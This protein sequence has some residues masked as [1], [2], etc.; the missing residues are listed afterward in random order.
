PTTVKSHS[1]PQ[2]TQIS[3]A[4]RA[5]LSEVYI[6]FSAFLDPKGRREKKKTSPDQFPSAAAE[7]GKGIDFFRPTIYNLQPATS[8]WQPTTGNKQPTTDNGQLP[9]FFY[10][11]NKKTC[12][13]LM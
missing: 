12:L 4:D 10:L 11:T 13:I 5:D 8:I 3:L 9:N 1:F 7:R 6:S 2:I